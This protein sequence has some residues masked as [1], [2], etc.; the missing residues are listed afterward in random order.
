VPQVP[1]SPKR[2]KPPKAATLTIAVDGAGVTP[3]AVPLRHLIEVLEAA[4]YT[5]EAIADEK[6]LD[7]PKLSL[8]NIKSGSA[9]Y[10]VY[11]EDRQAL[12]V[13]DTFVTAVRR[14]G[15]GASPKTRHGLERLHNAGARAGA[16]IR[17]GG[18]TSK[19]LLLAAPV[20]EA[21]AKIQ[22]ATVVFARVVGVN[23]DAREKVTVK[24]RYDDGGSHEFVADP[25]ILGNAAMLMGLSV[26]ARV[27]FARGESTDAALS[28]ESI[29]QRR[30]QGSFMALLEETRARMIEKGIVYDAMALIAEDREEDE[31]SAG[32]SEVASPE[33]DRG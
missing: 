15:K 32:P 31:S 20:P 24:L 29:K 7:P 22:E 11:S 1:K 13:F 26:E 3:K 33:R 27:I 23:I 8:A 10:Q 18:K 16:V 25:D 4:A 5:F 28:I 14:R 12:R 30:P 6:R 2:P 17:V 21:N 19:P 9:E